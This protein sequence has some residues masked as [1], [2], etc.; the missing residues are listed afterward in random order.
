MMAHDLARSPT[1][2]HRVQICGDAHLSNFGVF[3][4]RD[5]G[6]V[7][8]LNDFDE[9]S[10]GP[11]EWDLK[12]LAASVILSGHLS[13]RDGPAVSACRLG[14]RGSRCDADLPDLPCSQSGPLA[15]SEI[16]STTRIAWVLVL[17]VVPVFGV[18]LY[19]VFGEIRFNGALG[20]AHR[21]DS[22]LGRGE[23]GATRLG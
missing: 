7:L 19:F 8:D 18:V 12:R 16:N 15:R 13:L 20:R 1:A 6:L 22:P 9:T 5:R 11:F 4:G 10:V 14:H 2:G 21:A 23:R 17:L 3:A